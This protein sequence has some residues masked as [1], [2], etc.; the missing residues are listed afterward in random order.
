MEERRTF[1]GFSV[2]DCSPVLRAA[3]STKSPEN[4]LPASSSPTSAKCSIR[5]PNNVDASARCSCTREAVYSFKE[6]KE[7]EA[8]DVDE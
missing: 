8:A 6:M 3:P 7:T 1:C 2:V 4:E 5:P